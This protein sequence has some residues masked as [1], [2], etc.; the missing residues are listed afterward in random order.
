MF[1]CAGEVLHVSVLLQ[2][3]LS[4]TGF[5]LTTQVDYFSYIY[6]FWVQLIEW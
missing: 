4:G 2:R 1:T 5:S 6:K 3:V